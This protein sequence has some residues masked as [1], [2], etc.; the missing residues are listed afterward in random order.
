MARVYSSL[1]DVSGKPMKYRLTATPLGTAYHDGIVVG[2]ST[3]EIEGDGH[4]DVIPSDELIPPIPYR[5]VCCDSHGNVHVNTVANVSH[6]ISLSDV[7]PVHVPAHVVESLRGPVGP[8]GPVGPRGP[9]GDTGQRGPQGSRG[10][11]GEA[12]P[13]GPRGPIG[14]TG[15]VGPIGPTGAQGPQGDMSLAATESLID[16]KISMVTTNLPADN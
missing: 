9:R 7:T 15:D 16:A 2:V 6:D 11:Q 5:F 4:V 3:K 12:G 10:P 8:A 1:K 14:L 13:A